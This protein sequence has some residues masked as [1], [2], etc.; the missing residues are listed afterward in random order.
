MAQQAIKGLTEFTKSLIQK[1]LAI[2]G[3]VRAN[4]KF[5]P[6]CFAL[7]RKTRPYKKFD[8]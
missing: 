1:G 8:L 2:V 5:V 3:T 7:N 6:L 4:R